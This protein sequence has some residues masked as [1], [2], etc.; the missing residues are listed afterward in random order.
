MEYNA[1]IDYEL[2]TL[3]ENIERKQKL[4]RE[5]DSMLMRDKALTE[6]LELLK[7][8]KYDEQRDVDR[9]EGRT[10]ARLWYY[11]TKQTDEKLSREREQALA[12]AAKYEAVKAESIALTDRIFKAREEL[13]RLG[14]CES[15]YA[16][17]LK[18]KQSMIRAAL[19]DKDS[20]LSE[21]IES[22]ESAVNENKRKLKELDEAVSVGYAAKSTAVRILEKLDKAE[23]YS[24]WDIHGGGL[25][26]NINKH[27]LLDDAQNLIESLQCQLSRFNTELVDVDISTDMRLDID[28]AMK[29]ADFFFDGLISDLMVANRIKNA[30]DRVKSTE[31]AL[32]QTIELLEDMRRPL[33]DNYEQ[34]KAGLE[35]LINE[36]KL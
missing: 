34:D 9:L 3:R 14:S 27:D 18:E 15:R 12:A 17:K 24:A 5:L 16:D 31:Y 6:R 28:S 1:N 19:K 4:E 35:K 25:I 23:L 32:S 22:L 10:L 20:R 29:F 7:K 11:I 30:V 21:E 8:I 36:I 13:S 33:A 2:Q 26:A